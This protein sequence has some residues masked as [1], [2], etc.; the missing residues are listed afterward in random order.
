MTWIVILLFGLGIVIDTAGAFAFIAAMRQPQGTS[1]RQSLM[2]SG[3]AGMSV[4]CLF[5]VA[6]ALMMVRG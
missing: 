4:G 5:F 1:S 6:G 2:I 3:I